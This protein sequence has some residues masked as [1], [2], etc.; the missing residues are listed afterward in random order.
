MSGTEPD[1]EGLKRWLGEQIGLTFAPGRLADAQRKIHRA[2]MRAGVPD[3][4]AYGELIRSDN[5]ALDDLIAELTIGE[6]YF[7]REPGQFQLLR[8]LVLPELRRRLGYDHILRAW[9]AACSSGEEAYSLAIVLIEE[10]LAGRSFLLATDISREALSKARRGSYT[11]WSLRDE[12]AHAALPYLRR[13]DNRYVV[14]E[15]VRRRVAFAP[16]NLARDDYP[17]VATRT[18]QMD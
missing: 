7:F 18:Q 14:D 10:G 13:D 4:V 1:I 12:A 8:T 16:L 3:P 2:M 6:T 11:K 9:S 5:A 17:S 15:A